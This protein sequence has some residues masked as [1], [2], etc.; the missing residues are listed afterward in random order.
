M[1][2]LSL[3]FQLSNL[4]EKEGIFDIRV[5]VDGSLE[6]REEVRLAGQFSRQ[7][8]IPLK[9][10]PAGIYIVEVNGTKIQLPV[11]GEETPTQVPEEPPQEK[12]FIF[13]VTTEGQNR[14]WIFF[15]ALGGSLLLVAATLLRLLRWERATRPRA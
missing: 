3:T 6:V 10:R 7:L 4:G 5:V 9:G 14:P 13:E 12:V 11:S 2:P 1:E 15:A 8:T